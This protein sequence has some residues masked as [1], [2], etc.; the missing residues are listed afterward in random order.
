MVAPPNAL[1]HQLWSRRPLNRVW[2]SRYN[3]PMTKVL[4][5]LDERLLQRLD[6]EAASRRI[7]RSALISAL[8]ARGLGEPMGPGARP[9]VRE[10]LAELDRLF[11]RAESPDENSTLTIRAERDAR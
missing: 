1:G 10:N 11:S 2:I 3:L 6:S 4:V 9:A 7:S 8:V 5:S